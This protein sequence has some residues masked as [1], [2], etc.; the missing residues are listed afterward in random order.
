[1]KQAT[2]KCKCESTFCDKHKFAFATDPLDILA[3]AEKQ[4]ETPAL[5]AGPDGSGHACD[6]DFHAR[7][8]AILEKFNPKLHEKKQGGRDFVRI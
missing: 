4:P 2:N 8:K 6:F 3:F 7:G 1:M 5:P